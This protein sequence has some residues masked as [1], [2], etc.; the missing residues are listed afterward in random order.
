MFETVAAAFKTRVSETEEQCEG[1]A[2]EA[3]ENT[4]DGGGWWRLREETRGPSVSLLLIS[5][6]VNIQKNH[7]P[8]HSPPKL[9]AR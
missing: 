8:T 6:V 2:V 5:V 1:A 4:S 9:R 3:Y 7:D